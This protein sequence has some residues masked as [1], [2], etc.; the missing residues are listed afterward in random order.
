MRRKFQSIRGELR[1]ER[2]SG[3]S[4]FDGQKRF[5]ETSGSNYGMPELPSS[6]DSQLDPEKRMVKRNI[7][8][9][10]AILYEKSDDGVD[11]LQERGYSVN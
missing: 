9:E 7:R 8:Q 3:N 10:L 1:Y 6:I 2:L 11:L 5:G 4:Q